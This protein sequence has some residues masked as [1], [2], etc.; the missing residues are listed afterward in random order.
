M[1]TGPTIVRNNVVHSD[2]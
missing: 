1:E 2:W